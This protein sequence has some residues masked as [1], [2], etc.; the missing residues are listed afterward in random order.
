LR[1][2]PDRGFLSR[3][4]QCRR[5]FPGLRL[6][7]AVVAVAAGLALARLGAGCARD[8]EVGPPLLRW[9]VFREPS[10]AFDEA[11]RRCSERA[12][13]RYRVE[14]SALP[15]GADQQREQLVRRLAARDADID[16]IGMDVIWTA[17]FA[18][19]GWVKA[20][21][22]PLA[23]AV[24]AGTLEAAI[25]SG[26]FAGALFAA[27]F[28]TNVQLLWYRKDLVERPP[29]SFDEMIAQAERLADEDLPHEILVQAARYEGLAVW[30]NTLL[31][32]S[33][34][35]V[36]DADGEV[37]LP[38]APTL[39]AIR[40][41]R[42]LAR[43]RAAP[44]DLS[45][46]REDEA[47]L[48]FESGRAAFML[49]Y[50]FVWPS[51]RRNAPE[52]A[53]SLGFARYPRV[54]PDR[55][56]RVTVGGLNLGVGAFSEHPALALEAA[57]CLRGDE[58][59]LLAATRG[60]LLPT[61]EALYD[62]PEVRRAFPFAGLARET[63]RDASTRPATPAYPDV[64]LAIQRTLHPPADVDPEAALPALRKRVSRAVASRGLL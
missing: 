46:L 18:A 19:A 23:D 55:P 45:S 35:A 64:S 30:F 7:R 54:D 53:R 12:G 62:H 60:G 43:S 40:A 13:D 44:A 47:R 63:L 32:S 27:P 33:G 17:E 57:A 52:L 49:N 31:A 61:R 8:Q 2:V 26:S 28:T 38:A 39:R 25:E 4:V 14:V 24:R 41:M 3:S 20:W 11:A 36:L 56:S 29:H 37:A 22:E 50:P 15:A 59:Q 1:P 58:H 51:A 16:L 6:L 5:R 48:A 10:G 9:Y 42:A 21:P 34:G